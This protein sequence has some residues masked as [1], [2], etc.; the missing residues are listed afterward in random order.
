MKAQIFITI[1]FRLQ[2]KVIKNCLPF[3]FSFQF[4]LKHY[5]LCQPPAPAS[6][7]CTFISNP[8]AVLRAQPSPTHTQLF[9]LSFSLCTNRFCI[10]AL[11]K[12]EKKNPL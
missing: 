4:S 3:L 8:L 7:G 10:L 9:P 5:G 11:T 1:L 12:K 6:V 2:N